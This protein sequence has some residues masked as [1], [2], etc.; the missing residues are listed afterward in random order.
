MLPVHGHADIWGRGGTVLLTQ[1]FA[2][3]GDQR[4][5]SR[6]GRLT[7]GK[8]EPGTHWTGVRVGP[9]T[10]PNTSGKRKIRCPGQI[11]NTHIQACTGYF[12]RN[13]PVGMDDNKFH[14]IVFSPMLPT[15]RIWSLDGNGNRKILPTVKYWL[16][17]LTCT[18]SFLFFVCQTLS[19]CSYFAHGELNIIL[20]V[21]KHHPDDESSEVIWNVGKS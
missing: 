20:S 9:K 19:I 14:W 11:S 16:L 10:C 17:H 2:L 18:L 6:P 15:A 4:L 7:P 21:I 1:H 13:Y 8:R 12:K 3:D 5:A